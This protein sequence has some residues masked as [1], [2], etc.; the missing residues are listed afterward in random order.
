[1]AGETWLATERT[2]APV[3][4]LKRRCSA[5]SFLCRSLLRWLS[6][7]IFDLPPEAFFFLELGVLLESE[8]IE[9]ASRD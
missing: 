4:A 6:E 5:V 3:I 1:M 7:S 2:E 9:S 8:S